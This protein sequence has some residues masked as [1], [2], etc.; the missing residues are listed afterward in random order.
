MLVP[1]SNNTMQVIKAI[2]GFGPSSLTASE[3]L[4]DAQHLWEVSGMPGLNAFPC[5]RLRKTSPPSS[6]GSE[7]RPFVE[8]R[9]V[10]V[11]GG[12][13]RGS[14]REGFRWDRSPKVD[15]HNFALTQSSS[16]TNKNEIKTVHIARERERERE[17]PCQPWKEMQ[18]LGRL[19]NRGAWLNSRQGES[20]DSS[21][22]CVVVNCIHFA[23]QERPS[24]VSW[25][26]TRYEPGGAEGGGLAVSV[27]AKPVQS[28][29]ALQVTVTV[30]E[31][32]RLV[33]L[34]AM[35]QAP[36]TQWN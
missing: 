30:T 34:A 19:L 20:R 17:T 23:T 36:S 13:P 3:A 29:S 18:S 21:A 5:R 28:S 10:V 22:T 33:G 9:G 27:A 25:T 24:S 31:L 16:S 35:P 8:G 7:R 11:A 2:R 1:S 14:Q 32:Q 12:L 6:I 15:E 4:R 26:V